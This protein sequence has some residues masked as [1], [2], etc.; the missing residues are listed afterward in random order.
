MLSFK[1]IP[2]SSNFILNLKSIGKIAEI[3]ENNVSELKVFYDGKTDFKD[4]CKRLKDRFS[5]DNVSESSSTDKYTSYSVN[6][7]EQIVFCI[8]SKNGKEE[9]HNENT[10]MFFHGI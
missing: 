8:R 2:K 6:K 4:K 9:I 7:G 5:V 10:I 3:F 1:P